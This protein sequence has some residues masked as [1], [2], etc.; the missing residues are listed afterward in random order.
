[1]NNCGT[2]K[3]WTPPDMERVAWMQQFAEAPDADQ[4]DIDDANDRGVCGRIHM[5]GDDARPVS[6]EDLAHVEDGSRYRAELHTKPEFG[7][8]LW[9]P[10]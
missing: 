2:C 7:C 4:H 10:R 6:R 5:L 1:M 3:H 8:V 9:E